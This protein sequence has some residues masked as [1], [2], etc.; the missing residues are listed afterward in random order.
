MRDR[1]VKYSSKKES[2][3]R[4]KDRSLSSQKRLLKEV[5]GTPKNHLELKTVE[6]AL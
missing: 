4:S 6:K 2:N 3:E 1:S 5:E